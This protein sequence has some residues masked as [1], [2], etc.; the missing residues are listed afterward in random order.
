MTGQHWQG[1][2]PP[3]VVHEPAPIHRCAPP[4]YRPESEWRKVSPPPGWSRNRKAK[5]AVPTVYPAG[6]VWVCVCGRGWIKR[7]A[8]H[9]SNNPHYGYGIGDWTPVRWWH[10]R[11]KKRIDAYE[12]EAAYGRARA[13]VDSYV[14]PT[15]GNS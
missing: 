14:L 9:Y 1:G 7:P 13:I 10:R 6:T 3:A 2:L 8:P 15:G 12:R 4:R 11:V 5:L